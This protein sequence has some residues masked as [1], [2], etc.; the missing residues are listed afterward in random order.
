MN[1]AMPGVEC[2][3]DHALTAEHTLFA[4][5]LVE[6]I[7]VAHAVKQRQDSGVGPDRGCHG[8]DR[9]GERIGL[10]AQ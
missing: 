3:G 2:G 9:V 1:D 6:D 4:E 5:M 8:L 10:A 7:E